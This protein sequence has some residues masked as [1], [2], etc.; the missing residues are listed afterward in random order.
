M[1]EP[2]ETLNEL[3]GSSS[4]FQLKLSSNLEMK[5]SSE[6]MVLAK[7]MS[8]IWFIV[9]SRCSWCKRHTNQETNWVQNDSERRSSLLHEK[10]ETFFSHTIHTHT[11]VCEK[12]V[13]AF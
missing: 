3:S 10:V 12:N 1:G 13:S 8:E 5:S 9:W 11:Q 4:P 7:G 2:G 6:T